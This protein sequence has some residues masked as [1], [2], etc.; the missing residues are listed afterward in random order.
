MLLSAAALLIAATG[1]IMALGVAVRLKAL[2]EAALPPRMG[3]PLGSS[4]PR[5]PLTDLL[6]GDSKWLA[7]ALLLFASPDCGPCRDLLSALRGHFTKTARPVILIEPPSA[8]NESLAD[9]LDVPVIR[10]VDEAGAARSAFM[11]HAT[12]HTFRVRDG[13]VADQILGANVE[14]VLAMVGADA[15]PALSGTA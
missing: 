8:G 1:L 9:L 11:A 5:Q 10:V 14:R 12:P 7:D 6:G 13:R 4:V 3:L 15:S 2:E